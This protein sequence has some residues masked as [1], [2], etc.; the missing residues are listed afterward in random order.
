MVVGILTVK[1]WLWG[2]QFGL[3][4]W[5]S[6]KSDRYGS[7]QGGRHPT[8]LRRRSAASTIWQFAHPAAMVLLDASF[9]EGL[10]AVGE[11]VRSIRLCAWSLCCSLQDPRENV[12]VL[13]NVRSV[14]L[15][16]NHDAA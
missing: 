15:H 4:C 6:R 2:Q 5:P 9:S 13:A 12:I 1:S 7:R 3:A 10:Q 14:R 8:W 11:S 16:S